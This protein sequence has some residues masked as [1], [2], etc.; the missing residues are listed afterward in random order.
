MN[1]NRC[2]IPAATIRTRAEM[3]TLAGEIADLKNRQRACCA[4]MDAGLAEIRSHYATMLNGL[5]QEI[6]ARMAQARAWAESNPAEFGAAKSLVLTQAVVGYRTGQPQL[7][8]LPS[9][10]WD[11][12]LQQLKNLP[13]SAGLVRTRE[14]INKQQILAERAQLG[15]ARLRDMGLRIAQEESF[16]VEPKLTR[17]PPRETVAAC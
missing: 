7:K 9:W 13:W 12:V 10:T 4:E 17:V 3:E 14:E 15:A 16:Y 5:E 8:T 11:T 2:K 1:K 6:A